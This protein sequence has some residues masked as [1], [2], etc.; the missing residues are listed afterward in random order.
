MLCPKEILPHDVCKLYKF[1][2]KSMKNS[3][4]SVICIRPEA[5][6]RLYPYL[7]F[8]TTLDLWRKCVRNVQTRSTP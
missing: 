3:W 4:N 1:S 7:T 5:S 6:L 8:I 2:I